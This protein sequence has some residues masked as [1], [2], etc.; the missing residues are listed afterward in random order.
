MHPLD[1]IT[2]TYLCVYHRFP[3]YPSHLLLTYTGHLLLPISS[4]CLYNATWDSIIIYVHS[5]PPP[6]PPP[7]IPLPPPSHT[8]HLT[9]LIE[10]CHWGNPVLSWI[11]PQ[12]YSPAYPLALPLLCKYIQPIHESRNYSRLID[13]FKASAD[14]IC[15]IFRGSITA[16][17]AQQEKL[18][19]VSI[20]HWPAI[21]SFFLLKL[22]YCLL[23]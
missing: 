22:P 15:Y 16:L 1:F 6:A 3:S 11:D 23:F 5:V 17:Q 4:Y 2:P 8:V 9:L 12:N 10:L 14:M 21:Q 20:I 19:W 13:F 18:K 7:N